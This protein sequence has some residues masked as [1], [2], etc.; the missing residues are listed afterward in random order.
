MS[1]SAPLPLPYIVLIVVYHLFIV[2]DYWPL[3]SGLVPKEEKVGNP[4]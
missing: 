1:T 4:L 2:P 3:L